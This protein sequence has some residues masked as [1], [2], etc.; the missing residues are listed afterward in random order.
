M[1]VLLAEKISKQ[2]IDYLKEK[3]E[4]DERYGLTPD[5]LLE[6]IGAYD[7]IVIRSA[8][9]IT[10]EVIESG[11]NLKVIGRAGT[12]VDNIDTDAATDKGIIVV[13]TPT[14]NNVST[15]EHT[16]AMMLALCRNIP[17]A[18]LTLK[19]S[20]WMR[21]KFKGVELYGKTVGVL[22]LGRIGSIVANRLSGFGM[23]VIAYD[24]YISDQ[25]FEDLGV[26]RIKSVKEIISISDFITIHLPK[27]DE[28]EN[29]IGEKE[30]AV[31]KPN[32]RLVNCAR[33]GLVDEKALYNALKENKI[34]GAAVDAYITEPKEKEGGA[35]FNHPFLELDNIVLSPHLGASTKEAQEN[36]GIAIAEQ[37]CKALKGDVVSAV[38]LPG[39][40]VKNMNLLTPY[41]K[42]A[43]VLGKMYY[44]L[45][46]HPVR[47][48]ELIYSGEAAQ[49][50]TQLITLSY[51]SGLLDTI[52]KERVNFVNVKKLVKERGI[53]VVESIKSDV[54]Y[55]T[56]LFTVK[57][58][59]NDSSM[60]FAGTIFG[61]QDIRIVK[62]ADYDIDI[63]P[64]KNMIVAQNI[65][66]PGV[67]GDVGIMLG[68]NNVN[69]SSMQV[70][71]NKKDG[72][73][74][75]VLGIDKSVDSQ[76]ITEIEGIDGILNVKQIKL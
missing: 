67:I 45:E 71:S 35:E 8:S 24:P 44:Q 6:A 48:V 9:K 47:Q 32:L 53:K 70:S 16:V 29:I 14:S 4:V 12:G 26:E 17:K 59:N 55:Y 10:A 73:A 27:T 25:R 20:K 31:A 58:T 57:I 50:E 60:V 3:F 38:N 49:R 74:L 21:S 46:K 69:V 41:L 11:R 37:V 64:Y 19:N 15:A 18:Y 7:A 51:L 72:K 23:N 56:S 62:F 54:D 61:K 33:G 30:L 75:M 22:G 43:E 39:L 1:K 52:M 5:E 40:K 34:A 13:N 36:V 66:K 65:D 68:R 28:T 2:G 63:A 42:M 76:I